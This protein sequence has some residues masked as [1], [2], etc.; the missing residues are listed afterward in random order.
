MK[1]LVCTQTDSIRYACT[2]CT[3]R[4][5][6]WLRWTEL[7][8]TWLTL[9]GMLEPHRGQTG[10]RSP[11]YGSRPPA[12]LE[13][14]VMLDKRSTQGT[15]EDDHEQDAHWS[16]LGT[17]HGLANHVRHLADHSPPRHVTLAGEIGYLLAHIDWATHHPWI[18]DLAADI[19]E[20]HDQARN[21]CKDRPES[22][23]T[24]IQ[25]GC[26][27]PVYWMLHRDREEKARCVAC[28]HPYTGLDLVRLGMKAHAAKEATG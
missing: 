11:G 15:G 2:P 27:G 16:I 24:C 20:L 6:T 28:G 13:A 21:Q 7:Y 5:R 3:G 4:I 19:H 8:T 10:R 9:P 14:I 1:C 25:P 17:L 22:C 12:R 26:T 23:G 18:A